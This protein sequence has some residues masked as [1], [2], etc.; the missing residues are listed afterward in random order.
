MI[1]DVCADVAEETV[2]PATGEHKIAY[3]D[4]ADGKTHSV[5]CENSGEILNAAEAHTYGDY[6]EDVENPGWKYQ[7]CVHCGYIHREES[8]QTGDHSMIAVDAA[9]L[10]MLGIALVVSKKKEF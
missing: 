6:I 5:I 3:K 8:G 1:C 2:L 7:E 10:S 9:T 4:N